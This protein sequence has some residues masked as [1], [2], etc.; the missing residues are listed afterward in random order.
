MS[1]SSEP[2]PSLT[3]SRE[4]AHPQPARR[5]GAALIRA[6][7][8]TALDELARTSFEDLSFDKIAA[9]AGAGKASLY[10]RWRTPAELVLDALTDP[11]CGFGR[12]TA[13]DTGSMRT[14]L[15]TLLL[16]FAQ[17]LDKPHGRALRPL[18]TQRPRH[19]QLYEEVFQ[20]VVRPH[21]DLV[22]L[23]LQAGADRGEADPAAVTP[24]I[25]AVGPRLVIAEHIHTGTVTA[26]EVTAVVDEVLLPLTASP[27][28]E[29]P[30]SSRPRRPSRPVGE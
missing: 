26:A 16:G 22:L 27:S 6:I 24:R 13:P 9:K 2:A 25:A 7:Y 21:Q 4:P 30:S 18:M 17:A 29:E 23:V 20:Q 3:P 11:V 1:S 10:R 15:I 14:D 28:T 12:P 19:P 5:R 8:L